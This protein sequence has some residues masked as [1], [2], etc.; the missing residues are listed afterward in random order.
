MACT[1]AQRLT[2]RLATS[3][4]SLA[5]C[6]ACPVLCLSFQAAQDGPGPGNSGL[7]VLHGSSLHICTKA[8]SSVMLSMLPLFAPMQATAAMIQLTELRN[9]LKEALVSSTRGATGAQPGAGSRAG[10]GLGAAVASIP[11][12][13]RASVNRS[14]EGL[15]LQLQAFAVRAKT[16]MREA[17]VA[18]TKVAAAADAVMGGAKNGRDPS[19]VVLR[20]LA[21]T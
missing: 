3:S 12:L 17:L 5:R 18:A 21:G 19:Q 2:L 15:D 20:M 1:W 9:T 14:L 8:S 16:L 6:A 11:E 10:A 13:L 7:L 4:P